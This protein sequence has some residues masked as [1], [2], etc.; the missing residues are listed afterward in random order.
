MSVFSYH[1]VRLTLTSAARIMLFPINSKQIKGLIHAETMSAMILGS[2]IF[3]ITRIFN[4]EIAVFAQWENQDFLND[5]LNN[6]KKGKQIEK[7]WHIRLQYIRQWGRISGY[8]IPTKEEKIDND[9]SVVAVTIARMKYTQIPRFLRWGKPVEEQVRNN[10]GTTISLATIRYPNIISTF[11]IW[12]TQKEMT[13]MVYGHS[14]LPQPKRHINAMKE[15]DRKDFHFEFTTLRF[16]PLTEHGEWNNK[17][18]Y[19][20]NKNELL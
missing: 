12:K 7:G 15:R 9:N 8:Q 1:I 20:L 10:N 5:F 6:N 19:I 13:D 18:N 16:K 17:R 11:S 2:S 4:R 3:S 14:K